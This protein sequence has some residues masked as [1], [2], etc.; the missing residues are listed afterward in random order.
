[1]SYV[2][3]SRC[4]ISVRGGR[5]NLTGDN[6]PLSR[7]FWSM[8]HVSIQS[9]VVVVIGRRRRRAMGMAVV[10]YDPMA[11]GQVSRTIVVVT[12]AVDVFVARR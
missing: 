8:I 1:M 5:D 2:L 4:S 9:F 7:P 6:V 12:V 11:Q 3:R 10:T